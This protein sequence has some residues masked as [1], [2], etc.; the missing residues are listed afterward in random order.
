MLFRSR[1]VETWAGLRDVADKLQGTPVARNGGLLRQI[2][3][4]PP[5]LRA[6]VVDQLVADPAVSV[7]DALALAQGRKPAE[8]IQAKADDDL[9]ALKKL[10][11]K[12][13]PSVRAAFL[14]D[15]AGQSLPKG[16]TIVQGREA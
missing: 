10:W 3:A 8:V 2:A 16:W 4:T 7:T 9:A 11:G 1:A 6:K 13:K 14:E 12:A 5:D 15:L